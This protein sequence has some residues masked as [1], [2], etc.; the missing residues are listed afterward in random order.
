MAETQKYLVYKQIKTHFM[1]VE[2]KLNPQHGAENKIL[3]VSPFRP[4]H[5][6]LLPHL[7][8]NFV[9]LFFSFIL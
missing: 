6:I 9:F 1:L 7:M 5:K 3:F 2:D 4:T 8:Q